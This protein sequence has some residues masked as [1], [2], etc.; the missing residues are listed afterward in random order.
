[1]V[2]SFAILLGLSATLVTGNVAVIHTTTIDNE[3]LACS[4]MASSLPKLQTL[5]GTPHITVKTYHRT[6]T[7]HSD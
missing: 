3:G 2:C 7:I 6:E 4:I 1:M 5:T